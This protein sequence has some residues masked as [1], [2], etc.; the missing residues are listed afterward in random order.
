MGVCSEDALEP[1]D[2]E[3]DSAIC[4]RVAR[5][6]EL[7]PVNARRSLW[8]HK[9]SEGGFELKENGQPRATRA[10]HGTAPSDNIVGGQARAEDDKGEAG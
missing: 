6:S 9:V 2:C 1:E 10:K 8:C 3:L 7:P 4:A 5:M